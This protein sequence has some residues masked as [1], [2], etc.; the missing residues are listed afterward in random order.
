MQEFE[1]I[2]VAICVDE[3]PSLVHDRLCGNQN[4]PRNREFGWIG[5][6]HCAICGHRFH[7]TLCLHQHGVVEGKDQDVVTRNVCGTCFLMRKVGCK[8]CFMAVH[9]SDCADHKNVC[10]EEK[11][12]CERCGAPFARKDSGSHQRVCPE[13]IIVCASCGAEIARKDAAAHA[14]VCPEERISL[15]SAQSNDDL[16]QRADL[17]NFPRFLPL[18]KKRSVLKTISRTLGMARS[19]R[20][21]VTNMSSASLHVFCCSTNNSIMSTVGFKAGPS[22]V[23]LETSRTPTL[24]VMSFMVVASQQSELFRCCGDAYLSIFSAVEEGSKVLHLGNLLVERGVALLF[25]EHDLREG[26]SSNDLYASCVRRCGGMQNSSSSSSS[27][28]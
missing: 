6:D 10:A 8:K 26:Q 23:K 19:H 4:C 13:E 20:V 15:G 2:D 24:N 14:A 1:E 17:T 9:I 7:T 3:V 21:A 5:W 16:V 25:Y 11:V 27:S 12:P 22:G 28:S 18:E